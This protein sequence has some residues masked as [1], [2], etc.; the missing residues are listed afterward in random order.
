[1]FF[2]HKTN[3]DL[4]L[5]GKMST[6]GTDRFMLLIAIAVIIFVVALAINLIR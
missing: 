3:V 1:M 4:K 5:T 2:N 6:Q